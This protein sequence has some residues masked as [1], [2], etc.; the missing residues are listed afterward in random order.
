MSWLFSQAL[1]EE[2][3]ASTSL[4]GAPCAQLS[5]MPTPHKFWHNDKTM[6][7]SDLSRFGLTSRLLTDAHG[8]ELL[9]SFLEAFPART[10]VLPAAAQALTE[11]EA[12]CGLT[13]RASFARFDHTTFSWRTVQCSLLGGSDEFSE[14][15]PRWGSMRNGV[16]YLRPIP[17]LPICES[18]S[19]LWPT[20]T[21]SLGTKGGRIT[22]QK[23]REGGTLIEAIAARR[24]PTPKA[25]D[26]LKRGNFNAND[27]RNGLVGAVRQIGPG[28][29]SPD[30]TE[31]LMGWPIGWT[32][33]QPLET[34][35]FRE[36]Q[37]QHGGF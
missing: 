25:N 11:S 24:Y 22:P 18:A 34:A 13:W 1:V 20:P 5:V 33:L 3:S 2:Y 14:T 29:L 37:Q 35:R 21:A 15:W 4:D 27:K 8:A 36:W 31:W 12:D 9:T 26:A 28:L 32:A 30:W 19:G 16:S 10:S 7:A 17:A 6:D 23:G